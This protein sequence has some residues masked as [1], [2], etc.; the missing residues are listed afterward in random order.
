MIGRL[1]TI[2]VALVVALAGCDSDSTPLE[3]SAPTSSPT[4]STT[5]P[6]VRSVALGN[7]FL[8]HVRESVAVAGADVIVTYEEFLADSRCPIGV[9]C[10]QA[11]NATIAVSLAATGA[12]AATLQLNTTEGPVSGSYSSYTVALVNLFRGPSPAAT[13]RV[14]SV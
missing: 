7:E 8:I 11:G 4:S 3:T 12:E 6:P 13:L 14:T 10:I 2:V 5:A 1:A 9:Q